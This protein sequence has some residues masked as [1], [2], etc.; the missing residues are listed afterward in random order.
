MPRRLLSIWFPRLASDV[1]LRRRPVA[2]PFAL[3]MRTG[4]AD[5]L[6][7]LDPAAAAQGLH[8]GMALADARAIC[9]GLATRP[10]DPVQEAAAL[11]AL[12]RW[13]GR[14]APLVA[15]DGPDG[16][17]ADTTGTAHLFGG[18]A[19]LRADLHARLERAGIAA[20]SALAPTRGAAHALARHGGGIAAEGAVLNGIGALPVAALRLDP[21]TAAALGRLGLRRIADL[22]GLPRAPLA[23]RFGPGLALRLDQAMG[24]QPEPV[25]APPLPAH[26]GVRLTLPEPVGLTSDVMAGLSRLLDRLCAQLAAQHRGARRLRLELRRVDRET[27]GVEIGLARPMRDPARIAPLFAAG[28]AGVDAGYGIDAL[29]L[30]APLTEPLAPQQTGPHPAAPAEALADLISRLGNRLGFE[31][32]LRLLP[33]DSHIPERSFRLAPVAGDGAEPPPLAGPNPEH[34]FPALPERGAG[35]PYPAPGHGHAAP[36]LHPTPEAW[37]AA[38]RHPLPGHGFQPAMAASTGAELHPHPHPK[39]NYATEP[40]FQSA[41]EGWTAAKRH[42]LPGHGFHTAP[43]A[44]AGAEPHPH[45]K[46]NHA[47]EPSFRPAPAARS[48]GELHLFPGPRHAPERSIHISPAAWTATN[49]RPAP[50]KNPVP[51]QSQPALAA[52]SPAELHLFPGL[53][54]GSA[55]GFQ[56]VPAAET[57]AAPHPRPERH[58]LKHGSQPVPMAWTAAE[59]PP[60]PGPGGFQ[61]SS[62]AWPAAAPHLFSGHSHAAG[63]SFQPSPRAE[64]HPFPKHHVMERGSQPAP[65][66]GARA[67]LHP[68]PSQNPLPGRGLQPA[69]MAG[70][71][72][73]LH[74]FPGHRHSPHNG[75]GPAPA[76]AEPPR[77]P[78]HNALRGR[79]IPPAPAAAKPLSRPGHPLTVFPPEAVTAAAGHPPQHFTWRRQDFTTRHAAGPER[80]ASEWWR[81]DPAW[82]SGLRD[83]WRIDTAEGPRLW[84]FH[85]PQTGDWHTAGEFA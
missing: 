21:E 56:P 55:S 67:A 36:G 6:H 51:E 46:H 7:C 62:A 3:T 50:R 60:L 64:P 24:R 63:H 59:P 15:C 43:A 66:P 44:R 22:E 38:G 28:V 31:H 72:A 39:H 80:L 65:M 13:A 8:R 33:A 16:L 68:F 2:G 34:G 78:T 27:V 4:N 10:A 74:P 75:F 26:F 47:A 19:A 54:H 11:A 84:L 81:D 53:G 71:G 9:P 45:P 73:T 14:Y 18:E 79:S 58:G 61:P 17:I 85:S 32:V 82:R 40:G 20:A 48:V 42:P 83:Y 35:E 37:T 12:V 5:R 57:A 41:P 1:A 49:P 76:A 77:L 25:A 29:R 70:A 23:R 52:R 30:W 69:A